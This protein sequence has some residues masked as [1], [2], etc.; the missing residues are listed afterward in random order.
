MLQTEILTTLL[1]L[2]T[3]PILK[4]F[5]HISIIH[6]ANNNL[7]QLDLSSLM[8]LMQLIGSNMMLLTR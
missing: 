4:V 1:I 5:G 6:M 3:Q 2:T 7:D 8:E